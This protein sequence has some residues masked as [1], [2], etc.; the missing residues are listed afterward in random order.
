MCRR[1]VRDHLTMLF[2]NKFKICELFGIPVY[3]DISTA[4]LLIFFISL[5]C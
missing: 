1:K 5:P 4:I 2:G 3:L